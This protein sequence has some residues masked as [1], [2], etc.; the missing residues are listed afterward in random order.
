MSKF[1]VG[2]M[3]RIVDRGC[4][5]S[6]YE[7]FVKKHC[8]QLVTKF[9]PT[10]VLTN[11]E[12]GKV[13]AVARHLKAPNTYGDI[14]VILCREN[15]FVIEDKGVEPITNDFSIHITSDGKTTTAV[16]A[17]NSNV[18]HKAES[19]CSPDDKFDFETGAKLAFERLMEERK[20]KKEP[21]KPY[22]YVP[23]FG[24]YG[25]I[26]APTNYKDVL[27]KPLVVGDTVEIFKNGLNYGEKVVVNATIFKGK[28]FIMGIEA[29][30]DDKTGKISNDWK[31][32]KKREF[33]DIADNHKIGVITYITTEETH[34]ALQTD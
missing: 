9:R 2:D 8:P 26:G 6:A 28:C 21:F 18:I 20:P 33:A 11:G 3:V 7:T 34:N 30:C 17:E 12:I 23:P 27:D 4:N 5:F 10:N 16:L 19:K 32:I 24:N 29:D 13:K 31:I 22:L 15:V 25:V 14:L 1:K